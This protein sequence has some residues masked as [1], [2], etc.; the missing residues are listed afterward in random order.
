MTAPP[1]RILLFGGTGQV[2]SE[3]LR[4]PWPEPVRIEA[5]GRD[6]ADLLDPP[7]VAGLV[8]ADAVDLVINAAAY[9]AVDKAESEPETAETVNAAAPGA[10]AHAAADAGI[11]LIHLSTDYVFDGRKSSP[12]VEDDAIAPLS[13]YG[14][15]KAAGEAAVRAAEGRHAILRTSWVYSAH[16][17]NFVKTML[18]LGGERPVLRIV[19]D[20]HGAPTAASDIADA[21]MAVALRLIAGDGPDGVFHFTAAGATTWYGFA[22]RIFAHAAAGG[23]PVP[24]LEPIPTRNYPTPA[25][26]PTNSRLDCGRL[27]RAHGIVGRPWEAALAEVMDELLAPGFPA[28]EPER[29][30]A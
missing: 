10:L 2:G 30:S 19:D 17:G 25:R 3:L 29:G 22:S 6:T 12:Y 11:P 16:G 18:R 13:V 1:L 15:T 23:R 27:A 21:V 9:T 14:R 26:R 28:S 8:A 4:R 5:P 20:Q 24:K 7:R